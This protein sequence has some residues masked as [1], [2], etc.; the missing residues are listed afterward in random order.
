MPVTLQCKLDSMCRLRFNASL[1]Q[2]S[3]YVHYTF[4][5]TCLARFCASFTQCAG[6]ASVWASLLLTLSWKLSVW[7]I[8]L[9]MPWNGPSINVNED[10]PIQLMYWIL[11]T[12]KML[13]LICYNQSNS[14]FSLS[15]LWQGF[16]WLN[17]FWTFPGTPNEKFS[18]VDSMSEFF[19]GL[20]DVPFAFVKY[21]HWIA[22][23]LI[24]TLN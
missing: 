21:T 1:I 22:C 14:T 5:S 6:Y 3:G 16:R 8:V 20:Q 24:L 10:G 11:D 12:N 4:N 23:S 7:R 13:V 9:F 18:S 2:C 15:N 19:S 17:I